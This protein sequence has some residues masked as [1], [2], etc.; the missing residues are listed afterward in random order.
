MQYTRE[1]KEHRIK[2]LESDRRGFN[3]GLIAHE[4]VDF[5]PLFPHG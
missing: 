2:V 4:S 1:E 3:L 5:V